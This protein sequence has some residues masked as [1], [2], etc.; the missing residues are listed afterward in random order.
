VCKQ[1]EQATTDATGRLGL[2]AALQTGVPSRSTVYTYNPF[3]QVLTEQDALGHLTTHTYY[4]D[5]TPE[6][7]AGD[8]QA[9][10]QAT[11]SGTGKLTTYNRYNAHG[12]LLQMTDANG[13]VTLNSYDARQRLTSSSTSGRTI[14][15]S[16][17]A[18]GQLTRITQPDGAWIGWEYDAAHRQTAV[19]D[20]LG[21]RIQFTLDNAGHQTNE[22]VNDPTGSLRRSA[23]QALD[24]LSRLQQSQAQP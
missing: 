5:T 24:A 6:H 18:A 11:P 14:T 20:S 8:K 1:V 9:T 17:D 4:T 12:Q 3:G 23:A 16:Y 7:T 2:A 13:A 21:Q 15:Y 19:F 22:V 10:T